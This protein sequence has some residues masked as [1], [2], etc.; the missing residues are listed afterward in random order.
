MALQVFEPFETDINTVPST[1]WRWVWLGVD[2][3]TLTAT[4][5]LNAYVDGLA[6]A[7][8][9]QKI[10][11]RRYEITGM[12]FLYMANALDGE[13]PSGISRVIYNYVKANDEYFTN[14]FDTELDE[15]YAESRGAA[16]VGGTADLEV[17]FFEV[18]SAG[19]VAAGGEGDAEFVEG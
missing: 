7:T 10:G 16:A 1:Y 11:Q 6:F 8:G 2:V 18:Q 14:A 5:V 3:P 12:N 9:K 17:S 4:A 15:Y 19:M 13:N